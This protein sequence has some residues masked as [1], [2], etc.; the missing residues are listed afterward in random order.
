M[1]IVRTTEA[2]RGCGYRKEG[3]LYLMGGRPSMA[4][5]KLPRRLDVC[6]TC[7]GGIKQSR[8]WTWIE[9]APFF[10]DV[11][12]D[13]T[14]PHADGTDHPLSEKGCL[15]C[16][17]FDDNVILS[18]ALRVQAGLLWI[19]EGFYPTPADFLAEGVAQ[20]LSRRISA[21]PKDFK[22]GTTRI[23]L[24][25]PKAAP[26]WDDELGEFTDD[27]TGMGPGMFSSF[28]AE[29][30]HYVVTEEEAE[31]YEAAEGL[32]LYVFETQQVAEA[33]GTVQ[34][35]EADVAAVKK[36]RKLERQGITLVLPTRIDEHGQTVDEDGNLI[37][38]P[39]E[40][41]PAY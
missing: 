40:E 19:G 41:L 5:G 8:G 35:I 3:G 39:M 2:R 34:E 29:E 14:F 4:C 32:S 7:H 26:G 17:L 16:P 21:L 11:K 31:A 27:G 24:A 15:R 6:P 30:V 12:C 33:R 38:Q 36:L 1:S 22:V 23:F 10:L 28:V 20:G 13:Q 9:P 37:G 18:A 25:H